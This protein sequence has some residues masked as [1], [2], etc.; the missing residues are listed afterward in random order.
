MACDSAKWARLVEVLEILKVCYAYAP[1]RASARGRGVG[2]QQ[3][4]F[5]T[6]G[7]IPHELVIVLVALSSHNERCG[8]HVL[9]NKFEREMMSRSA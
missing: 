9:L 1:I 7:A 8:S 5:R 6:A 2:Q 4:P 3:E